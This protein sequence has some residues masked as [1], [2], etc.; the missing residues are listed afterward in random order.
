MRVVSLVLQGFAFS[1]GG[2]WNCGEAEQEGYCCKCY[3]FAQGAGV[4]DLS[5]QGET[6][7]CCEK[8][9]DGCGEGEGCGPD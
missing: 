4:A 5:C 3:W 1:F 2:E 9:A 8:A 6:Y 7:C